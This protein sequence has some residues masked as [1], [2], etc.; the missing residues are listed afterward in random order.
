VQRVLLWCRSPCSIEFSAHFRHAV[1]CNNTQPL[2]CWLLLDI[3]H[4]AIECSTTTIPRFI[5]HQQES[6]SLPIND[7][8]PKTQQ[9]SAQP[10][11][12]P[13]CSAI[14]HFGSPGSSCKPLCGGF[15]NKID[16]LRMSHF[17]AA[18]LKSTLIFQTSNQC[19][20]QT[21]D[22][23]PVGAIKPCDASSGS[24]QLGLAAPLACRGPRYWSPCGCSW[25]R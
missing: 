16:K 3:V 24:A 21:T 23:Y 20:G 15:H 5:I 18:P 17:C 7:Q 22:N 19:D 10:L 25:P 6:H 12:L 4:C 2:H 1:E 8:E 14:P 13:L 9:P 11:W